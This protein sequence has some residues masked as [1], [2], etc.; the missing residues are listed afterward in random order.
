MSDPPWLDWA[1]RI[2]AIG[3]TGLY[4]AKDPY[5]RER[6][7]QIR[8]IAAE[9][10]AYGA[11]ADVQHVRDIFCAETGYAT[12]KVDVRGVVFQ[13]DSVLLVLEALDGK[14]TL[15]GGWADVKLSPSEN[16]VKEVFEESGYEVRA[17]R[18]LAVYD[19]DKHPHPPGPFHIYKM[20]VECRIV[21]G[22]PRPSN[23]TLD[24]RFFPVDDLPELSVSRVTEEEIGRLHTLVSNGEMRADLD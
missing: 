21:G 24:V 7:E 20:F 14:W 13:E 1:K 8:E 10:V 18:L 6:Y 4:Y 15:P 22:E 23:E 9:M 16:A 5:D 3:Q 19:R 2:Q 17:E 11:E 12:P